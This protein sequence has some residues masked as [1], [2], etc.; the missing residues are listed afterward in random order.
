MSHS[1]AT[2]WYVLR[3]PSQD[4]QKI[5]L[6]LNQNG[7]NQFAPVKFD[8]VD[9]AVTRVQVLP[10]HVFVQGPLE[11]LDEI[12]REYDGDKLKYVMDAKNGRQLQFDNQLVQNFIKVA[13][14]HHEGISF[15]D[16]RREINVK[17][18]PMVRVVA[19]GPFK[20]VVGEYLRVRSNRCVVVR[21]GGLVTVATGFVKPD[22]VAELSPARK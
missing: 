18:G 5:I 4:F 1:D 11:R 9:G 19:D 7:V 12:K 6:Y 3:F 14:Q 17:H 2:C 22:E 15:L 20:D 10:G 21:L 13:K 8:E 16:S